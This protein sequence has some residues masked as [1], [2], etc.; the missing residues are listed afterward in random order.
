[1]KFFPVFL[2]LNKKHCV[3][4]GGGSV[5]ERK[6]KQLLPTGADITVISP[7]LTPGLE[8]LITA[9]RVKSKRRYFRKNDTNGAFLVIAATSDQEINTIIADD[10]PQLVNVVDIPEQCSFIMP[11]VMRKGPLTIAISSSGISP[12]LTKTLR[13]TLED[14]FPS[15]LSRYLAYLR[16]MRPKIVKTVAKSSSLAS[17]E[18]NHI[19]KELGSRRILDLL[20]KRGFSHVKHH[21]ENEILKG[22]G[23]I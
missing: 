22:T 7:C 9:K 16:K 3:V 23:L 5:A 10:A 17:V 2:N 20:K 15:E 18:K 6:V 21:I 4:I 1:M 11:S 8:K 13:K 19:L 14:F 12:A